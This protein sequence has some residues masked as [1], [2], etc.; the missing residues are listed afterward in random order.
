MKNQMLKKVNNFEV[1]YRIMRKIM[2]GKQI[3]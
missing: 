1:T 2:N 3:G